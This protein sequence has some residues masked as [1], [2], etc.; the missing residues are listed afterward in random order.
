MLALMLLRLSVPPTNDRGP[1]YMEQALAAV[2]GA[3]TRRMPLTLL[4]AQHDGEAALFLRLPRMLKTIVPSQL[5]AQ[6]PDCRLESVPDEA[7]GDVPREQVH[8]LSLTLAP[9][10]FPIRRHGQFEDS[11]NRTLADPLAIVLSALA[12]APR[13]NARMH[14]E[15][16][17]W[18]AR[19]RRQRRGKRIVSRLNRPF[20]RTHPRL[21]KVYLRWSLSR[22]PARRTG[23][24]LLGRCA[25]SGQGNAPSTLSVTS[26]RDHSREEDLQ[27]AADKLGRH[28]FECRLRLVA[29][30]DDTAAARRKLAELA[31]CLGQFSS[32]RLATFSPLPRRRHARSFLLSAEEV[33]TLFHPLLGTAKPATLAIV[34]SRE[35]EPPVRLPLRRVHDDLA[36]L[37]V[38]KFRGR[39]EPF[40]ILPDDRLR[41]LAILGKTGVGKTTLLQNLVASDIDAGR[42]LCCIDPHGDLIEALLS[43][44]PHRRTNEVVLFDVGDREHP[45]AFNPLDCREPRQ[46]PLVASSIVSAFKKAFGDSW[47][48]RLEYVLRNGLLALLEVPGSTLIDLQALLS[49]ESYRAR[50]V[51]RLADPIVRAFWAD[52]FG[53]LPLRLRSEW[54]SP[55]QNKV[56]ALVGQPILRGIV[57]QPRT[58]LDLRRVMDD[59]RVLLVNLAKGRVGEDASGLLGSIL[60]ALL[61]SAALARADQPEAVRRPFYAYVDEFHDFATD[62]F[63]S[64]MA[65]ARKY[66]LSMTLAT[67]YI[68]QMDEG[69]RAAIFGNAGTI[70]SFQV[71][72]SDAEVLASELGRDLTTS[73]LLKLP[74]F[75]AYVRLL[76]AGHP[77]RPF[78]MRTLPPQLPSIAQRPEVVR[79]TSRQR[80]C[81]PLV[82][83]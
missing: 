79:R 6:Y 24:W 30:S 57:G 21:A 12:R 35:L 51:A 47:G 42:G 45:L 1:L 50:V 72:Q 25:P 31:G 55:V 58:A 27:A 15:L 2:H 38:T 29:Q 10:I 75:Q 8:E 81:R 5:Y 40:G 63:A 62:T 19:S 37:G 20:F 41:H 28:L 61:Q 74:K 3:V 34:E 16:V 23:A 4:Y 7:F 43:S 17:V 54:V 77:S 68:E 22:S 65:E 52:E 70:V 36:I 33:A 18:R 9:D 78:S 76:I 83:A 14:M 59:G 56:G 32:P 71:G 67:Q 60:I 11:S 26:P 69:T 49:N 44:I 53:K 39:R 13:D 80:Y 48:P 64:T 73:D 66:R 82:A 46:R